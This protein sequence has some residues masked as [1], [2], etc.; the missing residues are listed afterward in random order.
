MKIK[1]YFFIGILFISAIVTAQEKKISGTVT[2]EDG[3]PL[4]GVNIVVENAKRG[5]QTD[6][7]GNYS[8]MAALRGFSIFF[9]WIWNS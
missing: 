6:F 7:D 5:T 9:C 1:T 3:L 2:G 4:I 8:I